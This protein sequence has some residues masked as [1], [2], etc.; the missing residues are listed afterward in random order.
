MMERHFCLDDGPGFKMIELECIDSTNNFL[1]TYRP[2]QPCDMTLVTAEFQ[3]KGRGQ[4]DHSWESE[5]GLNLLFSLKVHPRFLEAGKM[6]RISEITALAVYA[7]LAHYT[8]DISIKWPND[9]Y[10]KDK[11]ICGMLIEN[12]WM[13]KQL[14]QSII[15]VGININQPVF[16]SDAPNPVSLK[17]IIGKET[18]RRFVLELFMEHFTQYYK[19]LQQDEE[20]TIDALYK[21]MLYRKKGWHTYEDDNGRFQAKLYDVRPDGHLILED[22]KGDKRTYAFKEVRFILCTPDNKEF[23]L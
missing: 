22:D 11:K 12:D 10:W 19:M 8:E 14:E 9:I 5:K 7:A 16:T 15:G 13:G 21:Q 4:A 1:K 3:S 2:I 18:E 6:F 17:Q 23:C 20:D